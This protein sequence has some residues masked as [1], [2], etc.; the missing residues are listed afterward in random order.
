MSLYLSLNM[1]VYAYVNMY[2]HMCMF[3]AMYVY[4][5]AYVCVFVQSAHMTVIHITITSQHQTQTTPTVI[6]RVS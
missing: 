5:C 3:F 2:A 6:L 4:V 1:F